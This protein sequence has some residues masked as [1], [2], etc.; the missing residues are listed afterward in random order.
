MDTDEVDE[1]ERFLEYE[2][3]RSFKSIRVVEWA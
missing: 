1:L 3:S 2:S